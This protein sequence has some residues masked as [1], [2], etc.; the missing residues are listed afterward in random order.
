MDKENS[1]LEQLKS[2]AESKTSLYLTV[3]ENI[4]G[5]EKKEY[6]TGRETNL[7]FTKNTLGHGLMNDDFFKK[8]FADFVVRTS[9]EDLKAISISEVFCV[10]RAEPQNFPNIVNAFVPISCGDHGNPMGDD[11]IKTLVTD[12]LLNKKNLLVPVELHFPK[13]PL[14]K[15]ETYC[16][17]LLLALHSI[18]NRINAIGGFKESFTF[19]YFPMEMVQPVSKIMSC[20]VKITNGL[21]STDL[22]GV[23]AS[24]LRTEDL[25]VIYGTLRNIYK[26]LFFKE[27]VVVDGT[28]VCYPK[29][30]TYEVRVEK[31]SNF[32]LIVDAINEQDALEKAKLHLQDEDEIEKNYPFKPK[33]IV[34]ISTVYNLTTSN[35]S[36]KGVGG[37]NDETAEQ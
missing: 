32:N 36:I 2:W 17:K 24:S 18:V 13:F 19:G 11:E 29:K 35:W 7:H 26:K 8:L 28:K 1:I 30:K 34:P 25:D 14:G 12:V 27:L 21:Y 4:V 16:N 31:I 3:M 37:D 6:I 9:H 23:H 15:P 20:M 10:Y 5:N 22:G 33:N